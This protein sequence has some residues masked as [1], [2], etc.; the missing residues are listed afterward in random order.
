MQLSQSSHSSIVRGCH[1]VLFAL[2]LISTA[3]A[4]ADVEPESLAA[5]TRS[6]MALWHV[7]GMAMAVVNRDE[8][9]F[10]RG[11]G[12]TAVSDG[13]AVDEHTLYAIASTTNAMVVSGIL[14]LV[15][16]KKLSLDDPVIRHI[17]ELHY[18]DPM[19]TQQVTMR[20]LL[21][22]RTG[23]PSTDLWIFFQGMPLDEEITRLQTSRLSLPYI[24][25]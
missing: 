16:E 21:A 13:V 11:F 1:L 20:D 5:F 9:L 3:P 4:Q 15:D 2:L 24:P 10:Q 19:L 25:A 22:H 6:G 14:M 8:V 17:P 18:A 12:Q 7:P 23:L